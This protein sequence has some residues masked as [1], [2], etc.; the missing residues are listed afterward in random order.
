MV[1]LL[2]NK[3]WKKQKRIDNGADELDFVIDYTAF[4]NGQYEYT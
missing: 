1:L 3:K 2:P 4:K